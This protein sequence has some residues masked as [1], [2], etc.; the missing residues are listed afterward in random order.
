[1]SCKNFIRVWEKEKQKAV[2]KVSTMPAKQQ[3]VTT[4]QECAQDEKEDTT[5]LYIGLNISVKRLGL[6]K[7]VRL[8]LGVDDCCKSREVKS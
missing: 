1:M 3:M 2:V 7:L 5:Q 8:G 4:E 6:S